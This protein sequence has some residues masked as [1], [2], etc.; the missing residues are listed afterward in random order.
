MSLFSSIPYSPLLSENVHLAKNIIW[1]FLQQRQE[2]NHFTPMMRLLK[3]KS[4]C[5]FVCFALFSLQL[6]NEGLLADVLIDGGKW[7]LKLKTTPYLSWLYLLP[8]QP[9]PTP[10]CFCS[11][12]LW[13][14][15]KLCLHSDT[16]QVHTPFL[17]T[18]FWLW[19]WWNHPTVSS[20]LLR[21]QGL[22]LFPLIDWHDE[23]LIFECVE[24]AMWVSAVLVCYVY[25]CMGVC[26]W[27]GGNWCIIQQR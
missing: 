9:T 7:I 11:L 25:K 8:P 18:S 16:F 20:C 13:A 10:D 15:Q 19:S 3:K 1:G 17:G 21:W 5:L 24:V 2:K 12:Q 27:K 22:R 14:P 26:I 4:I 23:D 6:P